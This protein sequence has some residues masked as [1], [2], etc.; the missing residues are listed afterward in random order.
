MQTLLQWNSNKHYIWWVCV[1]SLSYPTSNAHAPYCY[2]WSASLYNIFLH[3]FINCKIF[4][5]KFLNTK[6]VFWFPL[7]ILSEIFLI[8]RIIERDMIKKFILVFVNSNR[9]YYPIFIK[10]EFSWK[11]FR[12]I[13]KYKISWK[14]FQWEPSSSTRTDGQILRS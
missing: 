5:R 14:S 8:L 1:C 4:K 2:L 10:L 12:K 11:S 6:C 9:Y 7:Q 3:Y 13:F